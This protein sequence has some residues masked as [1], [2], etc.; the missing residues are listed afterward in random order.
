M[1]SELEFDAPSSLH[2]RGDSH[3]RAEVTL[4]VVRGM[5]CSGAKVSSRGGAYYAYHNVCGA[6][7]SVW[8]RGVDAIQMNSVCIHPLALSS[9]ANKSEF[10]STTRINA[11]RPGPSV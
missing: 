11:P 2:T 4:A 8:K 6:N 10:A 9:S 1:T 7:E 3:T 5:G